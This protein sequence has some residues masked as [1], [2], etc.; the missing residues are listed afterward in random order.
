MKIASWNIR[1]FNHPLKQNGAKLLIHSNQID[2]VAILETKS[3]IS[4]VQKF[5]NN[6]LKGWKFVDNSDCAHGGRIFVLWNPALV[7]LV[8][9]QKQGQVVHCLVNCRI[10]STTMRVSFIYAAN[11][12]VIRRDLWQNLLEYGEQLEEPWLILG[13]FNN[14]LNPEERSNGR[15]VS[16]YETRNFGDCCSSLGLSDLHSVGMFFTWS[17]NTVLSKLDRAMVNNSWRDS[18]MFGLA[19]FLPAGCISDHSPCIVSLINPGTRNKPAFRFFN[20]WS[21]HPDFQN[22]VTNS[23]NLD[24]RGTAQFSLCNRQKAMKSVLSILNQRH[25]S[26]I[27]ERVKAANTALKSAEINLQNDPTNQSR[28]AEVKVLKHSAL[29]LINAERSFLQQKAK[30]DFL[31]HSDKSSKFFHALVKRNVN[32]NFIA[33]VTLTDG[34]FTASMDEVINAFVNHFADLLGSRAVVIPIDQEILNSGPVLAEGSIHGLIDTISDGEIKEALFGIG[35]NKSPGP[36]GFSAKFYKAA[37]TTVGP[38][39]S[40]AVREFFANSALLKQINHTVIALI[41]KSAHAAMVG[42]YRPIACCNVIYKIISKILAGRIRPLLDFLVDKAQSAFIPGRLMSDNIFLMQEILRGYNRKRSSPRCTIKIDISK[43][44][45]SISWDFLQQVLVGL[46]F[47]LQFVGWIME[48]VTSTSFSVSINGN[49]HGFFKGRRGLRQ[50]DPLSPYLFILCLDYLS[51]MLKTASANPDFNFHPKCG[52]LKISHLA[53]ADDLMLLARGD[54]GSIGILMD[55]LKGFGNCSG[56]NMNLQK[57]NIFLA[58]LGPQHCDNILAESQLSL[59]TMPF[60]YLGIPMAASSLKVQ[61]FSPFLAALNSLFNGWRGITLSYAGKVELIRSV[62]QG[63]HCFWLSIFPIPA[64]INSIICSLCRQFLW[65]SKS[66]QVA[67]SEIC[68]PL[69]EGGLSIRD[70][71]A[72]NSALI[73]KILWDISSLKESLWIKW[74]HHHYLG[75]FSIWSKVVHARDSPLLKRILGIRDRL[76]L[77]CGSAEAAHSKLRDWF[78]A[79]ISKKN[80]AYDFFRIHS[81]PKPWASLVWDSIIPPKFSFILWLAM[82]KKLNTKDRLQFLG[83]NPACVLCYSQ[84]E[85]IEHLFF[86]CSFSQVIWTAIRGWMRFHRSASTLPG[87]AK[88]L[89]KSVRGTSWQAKA[90]RFAFACTV[91]YIWSARNKRIFEGTAPSLQGLILQIKTL[92]Y[93]VIYSRFPHV[94]NYSLSLGS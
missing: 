91:Y 48:C 54:S 88:W 8:L 6:K 37:W 31:I 51:R 30:C 10:S 85:S 83:I 3:N 46:R 74:V 73:A 92:V 93:S 18:G 43:A 19:N 69:K 25:F 68:L 52:S 66:A 21:L 78:N 44:Y 94:E 56:L 80:R 86:H 61:D 2:V 60:R 57:S 77:S 75:R 59:G 64:S 28:L 89:R 45:D 35:D 82:K 15:N 34:S 55:C 33:A 41:P 84:P 27:S 26:H 20:M 40:A 17:N 70:L 39:V 13:D 22:V 24:V 9:L 12:L 79:A 36:D 42:D 16:P 67:W 14:I 53:F 50:G 63:V 71:K 38:S 4:K 32:R 62:L 65:G 5:I 11:S 58:G 7:D 29:L 90:K 76:L 23:W 1:G 87:I 81:L 49:T 72:W 47:P